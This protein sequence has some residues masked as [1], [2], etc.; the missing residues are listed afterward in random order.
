MLCFASINAAGRQKVNYIHVCLL[1]VPVCIYGGK[2]CE[3]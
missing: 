2:F 1:G 3:R